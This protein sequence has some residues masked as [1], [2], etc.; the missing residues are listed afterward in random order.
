MD[1]DAA[2][3]SVGVLAA[4][5]PGPWTDDVI[6][7][8]ADSFSKLGDP[9]VLKQVVQRFAL[10]WT[11]MFRPSLGQ[12]VEAYD[13]A[14]RWKRARAL[15]SAAQVHCDGSG[16]IATGAGLRPCRRCNPAAHEVF[17]DSDKLDRWRDGTQLV[18]LDVSVERGKGGATKFANGAPPICSPAIDGSVMVLPPATG[19]DVARQA[20]ELECVAAGRTPNLDRFARMLGG[21]R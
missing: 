6:D 17:T 4:A 18:E 12:V 16:W 9:V 2:Y 15:P 5:T 14:Q 7:V 3:A 1:I 10:N 8:W 13:E 21:P 11:G 20:Y 19:I